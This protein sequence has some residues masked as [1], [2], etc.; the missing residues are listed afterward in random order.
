M[1]LWLS[2]RIFRRLIARVRID[3]GLA[4]AERMT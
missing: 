4:S 3:A 1:R 2:G